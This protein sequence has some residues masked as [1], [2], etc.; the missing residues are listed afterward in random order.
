M[1]PGIVTGV[2]DQS[3]EHNIF[4]DGPLR[5]GGI[6]DVKG[7]VVAVASAVYTAGGNATETA[8]FGVPIRT[9]CARVLVCSGAFAASEAKAPVE[10][11]PLGP[12]TTAGST[13]TRQ[14]T[15]EPAASDAPVTDEP[16]V[17]G[18][19]SDEP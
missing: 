6:V 7:E 9:S 16:A 13:A 4:V 19:V 3:L 5:G 1:K 2:S 15:T 10:S 12:T 14:A 8:F 18:P 17:D 11:T